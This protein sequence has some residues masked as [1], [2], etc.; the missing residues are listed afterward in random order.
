MELT[1]YMNLHHRAVGFSHMTSFHIISSQLSTALGNIPSF[2]QY[3][4]A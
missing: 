3:T 4:K 1:T 2:V